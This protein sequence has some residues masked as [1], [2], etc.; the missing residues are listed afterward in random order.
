MKIT[1]LT[2]PYIWAWIYV[3]LISI[4]STHT[5]HLY[6]KDE[7]VSITPDFAKFSLSLEGICF[8]LFKKNISLQEIKLINNGIQFADWKFILEKN[9]FF[10][11]LTSIQELELKPTLDSDIYYA[12][13]QLDNYVK[14]ANFKLNGVYKVAGNSLETIRELDI[15][16]V[17]VLSKNFSKKYRVQ[18][19][20]L[21]QISNLKRK[22]EIEIE[23]IEDIQ[24]ATPTEARSQA[25]NMI[26]EFGEFIH[27]ISFKSK[28][29]KI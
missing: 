18:G 19:V 12:Y 5:C 16:D 10:F 17:I 28:S 2:I 29:T 22:I 9:S 7:C 27:W 1:T 23:L 8:I 25:E 20:A 11:A 26:A 15:N 24:A 6:F 14:T 13:L 3:E 21:V 4:Y